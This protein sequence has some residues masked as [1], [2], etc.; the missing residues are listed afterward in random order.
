MQ[1]SDEAQRWGL[2]CL[3]FLRH[4]KVPVRLWV[5]TE[6]GFALAS[7]ESIREFVV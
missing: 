6:L 5:R 1:R 2:L 7:T 4:S 3:L